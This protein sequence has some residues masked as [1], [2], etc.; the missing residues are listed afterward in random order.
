MLALLGLSAVLGV[1]DKLNFLWVVGSLIA[2][3]LLIYGREVISALRDDPRSRLILMISTI[4]GVGVTLLLAV[5]ASEL[6]F[7][8]PTFDL[9]FQISHVW[10]LLTL[11]LNQGPWGHVFRGE[12]WPGLNLAWMVF[13]AGLVVGWILVPATPY[14]R[15]KL[16]RSNSV[17]RPRC[18]RSFPDIDNFHFDYRHGCDQGNRR[19]PSRDCSQPTL[20]VAGRIVRWGVGRS[21]WPLLAVATRISLRAACDRRCTSRGSQCGG[22][23]RISSCS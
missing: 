17:L 4:A 9:G 20:A 5:P 16:G 15:A 1:Y 2:S 7:G 19:P 18:I 12:P 10:A 6:S 3:L 22:S 14:L 21:R 23:G 11:T 8:R 13:V